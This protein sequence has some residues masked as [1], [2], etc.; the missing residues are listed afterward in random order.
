LTFPSVNMP[1]TVASVL[2]KLS[3]SSASPD[4][5]ETSKSASPIIGLGPPLTEGYV[6]AGFGSVFETV[7]FAGA[8][9]LMFGTAIWWL[10]KKQ[11]TLA[12]Y[13]TVQYN[14]V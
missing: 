14:G 9:I 1:S 4:E 13:S 10:C 5:V 2:L 11:A 12:Q 7:G 8:L 6:D 3:V